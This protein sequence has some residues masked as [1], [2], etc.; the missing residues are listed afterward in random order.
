MLDK[1]AE[2]ASK[3]SFVEGV[4][5]FD[6]TPTEL[7]WEAVVLKAYFS[8]RQLMAHGFYTPPN[9][10]YDGVTGKGRPFHYY[11]YGTCHIETT[12]DCLR[13]TYTIDAIRLVHDLGRGIVPLID[14]GQIEGGLAQGIG[15]VTLEE[16]AFD[17]KGRT[18]SHALSTYKAPDGEFLPDTFDVKFLEN[19]NNE[20]GPL[21]SKAVGEPPFMYGMAAYF[22]LRDAV[23]AFRGKPLGGPFVSPATPEQV[24]LGLYG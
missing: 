19:V 16:L 6:G 11:T 18:T 9:I 5:Y 21:G 12:V 20:G 1:D 24:L 4:A 14:L 22:A 2:D 13:G 7:L 3:V 17:E 8:R 10:H 15:W 23:S